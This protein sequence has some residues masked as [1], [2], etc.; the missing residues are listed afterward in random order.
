MLYS[1][2]LLYEYS[3]VE[4]RVSWLRDG[5]VDSILLDLCQL[6]SRMWLPGWL[7]VYLLEYG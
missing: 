6:F 5:M 2:Y 3:N 7:D 1:M 4:C